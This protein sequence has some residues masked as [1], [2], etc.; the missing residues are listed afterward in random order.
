MLPLFK[1]E[2]N[3]AELQ[4]VLKKALIDIC[5]PVAA[6]VGIEQI[7]R[8]TELGVDADYQPFEPYVPQ[9]AKY[10]RAAKGFQTQPVNLYRTGGY[11]RSRY[12]NKPDSAI[13]VRDE[14]ER[15]GQG[16]TKKRVH[17]ALNEKDIPLIEERM[18]RALEQYFR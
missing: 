11:Q 16:L 3:T 8:R 7:N 5:I 10:G 4:N 18:A 13:E 6:N 9:Y 2:I 15:I 1:V 12:F 17:H 14:Y